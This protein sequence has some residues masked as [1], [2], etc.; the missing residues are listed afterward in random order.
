[1]TT[2][3]QAEVDGLPSRPSPTGPATDATLETYTVT[4]DR[5][6][7]PERAIMA[8]LDGGGSRHWAESSDAATMAELLAA[9][10]C[11]RPVAIDD[12]QAT[13]G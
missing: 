1:M 13:L 11:D 7:R 3:A 8:C 4:F 9:D 12:R 10:C 2:D 6:M 5:E